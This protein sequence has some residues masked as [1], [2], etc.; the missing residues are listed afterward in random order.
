M[1][2][3]LIFI[4]LLCMLPLAAINKL[5]V[6]IVVD[7]LSYDIL[8][9]TVPHLTGGIKKL[10][11][12]SVRYENAHFPYAGTSTGPGHSTI[13]TGCLP[14]VHGIIDNAWYDAT[15]NKIKCTQDTALQS[16]VFSPT[17]IYDFGASARN[18]KA[19]CISDQLILQACPKTK[20]YC[21]AI[22][23]KDRAAICMAGRMGTAVW[24]DKKSGMFTSSK[25]YF[26]QLPS[27][28]IKLNKNHAPIRE[29]ALK[30]KSVFAANHEAYCHT[31]DQYEFAHHESLF[32]KTSTINPESANAFGLLIKYPE[33]NKMIFDCAQAWIE[34]INKEKAK[35]HNVLLWIGLS[36]TDKIA[37]E[38]G[39]DSKEYT[40]IIYH[41]DKYL[42]SFMEFI[43]RHADAQEIMFCFTADHGNFSMPELLQR[44]GFSLAHRIIAGDLQ[45]KLNRTIAKKFNLKDVVLKIDFPS[46]FL[47]QQCISQLMP[48]EQTE[49]LDTIKRKLR[50]IH[51]IK[52]I[53]RF[54]ELQ[55]MFTQPDDLT[56]YFKNQLFEG[57]SGQIQYQ[58][59]PYSFMS[60]TS[61]G[62]SHSSPYNYTTQVPLLLNMPNHRAQ[63]INKK[64]YMTQVAPTIA[65]FFDCT[66]PS[67]CTASIVPGI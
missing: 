63:R 42:E 28:L 47:N 15:G 7:G 39:P 37:H 29:N 49:L 25:A 12:N 10:W 32:G 67:A 66:K 48:N 40:D 62:S 23:G 18:I 3:L 35:P 58:L 5:A 46:I 34:N 16:G 11:S 21:A 36:S 60:K 20:N 2:R 22:T 24:I 53:W 65:H 61:K 54:D 13:S 59:L 14:K 64:V 26:E 38:Y 41:I 9:K 17:G 6:I 43:E 50:T 27:W 30:W 4:S 45:K 33:S 1:K 56:N 51:G 8:K 57:R 55:S 31:I 44:K 52:N 19:D